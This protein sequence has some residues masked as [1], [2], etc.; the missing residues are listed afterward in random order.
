M[1]AYSVSRNS[2][3]L[4][5]MRATIVV[6][7]MALVFGSP[8]QAGGVTV[9]NDQASFLAAAGQVITEDFEGEPLIGTPDSGAMTLI[10]FDDFT[11]TSNPAALKVLNVEW[12]GNH[13]TTPAGS[14]YL[15]A[16]TD[17]GWQSS[18]VSL[19]FDFPVS[20]FGLYLID[21]EDFVVLTVNGNEYTV[22]AN[23]D[24]GESYFGIVADSP[25]TLVHMDMGIED[26][27]TSMDDIA[28]TPEPATIM[29]LGLGGLALIR[30]RK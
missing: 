9:F 7:V 28:Y 12:Y 13:N 16:D 22:P 19:T 1:D 8:Q 29:L 24:G 21:I 20:A 10:A 3:F 5:K 30:R 11:A 27:H 17:I 23:G 14:K 25:F 4:C 26:S 18:E 6:A 15:S 2:V